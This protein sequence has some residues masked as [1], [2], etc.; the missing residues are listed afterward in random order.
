MEPADQPGPHSAQVV[1]A[2]G[3]RRMISLWSAISTRRSES[4]RRAATATESASS[5]RSSRAA[6]AE[7]PDPRG[8]RRR[9]VEHVLAGIDELLCQQVAE[10]AGRLDGPGPLDEGLGPGEQLC[11][12]LARRRTVTLATS[13]SSPQMATAVW[14]ALWGSTPMITIM[15]TSSWVDG[16]REGT[17]DSDLVHTP[18]SSHIAARSRREA[19]RS[20]ANRDLPGGRH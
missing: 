9:D 19:I 14:L 7:D 18:L 12:L 13:R 15:S 4:E 1:V 17:P 2:L 20:K 3:Q 16:N 8:E 10:A 6:R 11:R 5:G